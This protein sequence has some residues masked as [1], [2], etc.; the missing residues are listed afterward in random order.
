LEMQVAASRA[1]VIVSAAYLSGLHFTIR[2]SSYNATSNHNFKS[3][4]S[5]AYYYFAKMFCRKVR[6]K[7]LSASARAWW[8][9]RA[10]DRRV[11]FYAEYHHQ[12]C[13]HPKSSNPISE[14]I[15]RRALFDFEW[16][17]N[18]NGLKRVVVEKCSPSER[19]G[20]DA[21]VELEVLPLWSSQ[22]LAPRPPPKPNAPRDAKL[23]YRD[24]PAELDTLITNCIKAMSPPG[25]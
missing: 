6:H 12:S 19:C 13:T 22:H 20:V 3:M 18:F 21:E 9:K 7:G 1:H 24:M 10:G 11:G 2:S 17:T 15:S 5:A 8:M 14:A 4:P 25:M 16:M 23:A